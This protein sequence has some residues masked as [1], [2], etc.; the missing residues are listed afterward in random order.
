MEVFG[1]K[2]DSEALLPSRS[3]FCCFG[4]SRGSYFSNNPKTSMGCTQEQSINL[5]NLENKGFRQ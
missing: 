5:S 4:S 3:R 2:S 1:M